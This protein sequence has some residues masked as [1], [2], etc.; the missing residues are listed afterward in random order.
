MRQL[1]DLVGRAPRR[2]LELPSWLERLIAAGIVTTDPEVARRQRLCNVAAFATAA[3]ALI[4]LASN[5]LYSLDG[6]LVIH[7][8][9]V[10]MAAL[11]L[12]TTRMH[13]LGDN[14]AA[15]ALILLILTGNTFVVLALGVTSDLQIYFTLAGA[16]L[17]LFGVQ[18]WRLFFAFF[19]PTAILLVL[20]LNFAPVD[21]FVLPEDGPLRDLLSTDAYLSALVINAALIFY[22][23]TAL[24]SAEAALAE[25]HARSETLLAAI[26]PPSIASRLKSGAEARVAD[27]IDGLSVMFADLVGFTEA[28]HDLPPDSI[29][30]YLDG[31]VRSFEAMC[32]QHG[33]DKIKSIGDG[34]MAVAGLQGEPRAGARALG[35]L[36]LDMLAH[37]AA[38]PPLGRHR[39]GLRIGLHCGPATAGV[40][41]GTRFSYD[42]WGDA[43][44]VA[45][46][47]E[48]TGETGRIQVSEAF[49]RLAGE[50]FVCQ[51][52]GPVDIKGLGVVETFWLTGVSPRAP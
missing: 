49:R 28:S 30:A 34:F 6:L 32:E 25:Q 8:Y 33:V 9:N 39:L 24:R 16:M 15:I 19:L 41:G 5:A 31:L 18:N 7:V 42:V 12:A 14:V 45:A 26:M 20:I 47:M 52:R 29:V 46:R 51:P 36:A 48:S 22:A 38:Q 21:G 17:F 37:H 3:D 1:H 4:H 2:G 43:V 44:N 27:R 13:R 23:L 11:A 35:E 50:A 40:I 10:I